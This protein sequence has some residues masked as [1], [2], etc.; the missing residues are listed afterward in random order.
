MSLNDHMHALEI[1]LFF[2]SYTQY[3][4]KLWFARNQ[5]LPANL[6]AM[7]AQEAN[8]SYYEHIFN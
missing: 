1:L 6:K 5:I 8:L 4:V 3:S 7:P 2:M